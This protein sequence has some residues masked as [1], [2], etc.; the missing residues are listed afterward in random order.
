MYKLGADNRDADALSRRSHIAKLQ[1]ICAAVPSWLDVVISSYESDSMAHEL[2]AKLAISDGAEPNFSLKQGLIRHHGRIWVGSDSSV[3]KKSLKLSM[4][5]LLGAIL[6]FQQHTDVLSSCSVS[7]ILSNNSSLRAHLVN[8]RSPTILGTQVSSNPCLFQL[9]L[10]KVS[11][12]TLLKVCLL[13][14][15]KNCILVIIDRFSKHAHFIMM[16]HP[17]TAQTVAKLFLQHVY[18]L[19]GCGRTT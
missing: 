9:W 4:P 2:L 1:S 11:R 16:S 8:R 10:G 5:R 19:H 17:F 18:R 15:G 14:G 3:S 13:L 6:G 12:W 7:R